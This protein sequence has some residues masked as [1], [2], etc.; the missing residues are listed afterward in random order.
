MV[1]K[2]A[3]GAGGVAN[4]IQ[5]SAD[6]GLLN[7]VFV[8]GVGI[9]PVVMSMS[10]LLYRAWDAVT[11]ALMGW[12]SDNTR[13]RWGRRRPYIFVGAILMAI[14]MPVLFMFDPKWSV[15]MITAWMIVISLIL[16]LTNTI[17]NIPYQSLLMEMTADSNERTSVA[18]W[19]AYFGITTQ[20]VVSWIWWIT[21]Q[22]IFHVNGEPNALNGAR[23]V[24]L[25]MALFVIVLGVL[26]AFFVKERFYKNASK[27]AKVSLKD[28]FKF[29]F[30]NKPFLLLLGFIL[31]FSLGVFS[32][33]QLGFFTQFFYVFQGD[34]ILA[35]EIKGIEGTLKIGVTF[36]AIPIFQYIA[37]RTSKK[38]SLGLTVL[39]QLMS[40][41]STWFFYNPNYPYM[42]I[43]P[44]IFFAASMSAMWVMIPSLTGDIVDDDEWNTG[45]R[46]EG[47]FSSVFSWFLKMS[48]TTA[49][50]L[51]GPLIILAGF[52]VSQKNMMPPPDVITNMR[53]ILVIIPAIFISISFWFIYKIPLTT[54][55]I[56]ETRQ[57]L[58]A[59]RGNI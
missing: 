34:Q 4:G 58:E 19:R 27:Q 12:V 43:L 25:G 11:D 17:Y 9:S 31:F 44:M 23:W 45:E 32:K 28:N 42:C 1:S 18:A 26:P 24:M 40:S 53:L 7:P 54:Q 41:L 5:E 37:K 55:R 13:T 30:T 59:R 22:P 33:S 47:A 38:F 56:N 3:Y 57:K 49:G 21:L 39:V 16:Y 51:A 48:S 8:L 6:N 52:D 29:T 50:A 14:V 10:S 35:S 36:A 46:R 20:F 15:G 2:A